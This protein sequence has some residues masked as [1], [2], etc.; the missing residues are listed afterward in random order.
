MQRVEQAGA[1]PF[2][3]VAGRPR[4]RLVK[5]KHTPTEWI[6]PKGHIEPG[7]TREPAAVRELSEEAGI[8]GRT[9]ARREPLTFRGGNEAV[10]VHYCLVRYEGQPVSRE[11]CAR[12]HQSS[13]K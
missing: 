11:P 12:H 6:F 1:I 8:L 7:E 2:T 9:M 13:T 3:V 4:I 10:R 5:A